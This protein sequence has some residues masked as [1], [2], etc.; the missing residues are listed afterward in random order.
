MNRQNTLKTG[1]GNFLRYSVL[2][3]VS[4]IGRVT[5]SDRDKIFNI[6]Y[7]QFIN[8]RNARKLSVPLNQR[9]NRLQ[10]NGRSD[11]F[12]LFPSVNEIRSL[13]ATQILF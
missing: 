8:R 6:K 5:D 7:R 1:K 9:K 4:G 11:S 13:G 2:V 10:H 3:S 12:L